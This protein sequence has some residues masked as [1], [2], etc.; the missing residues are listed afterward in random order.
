MRWHKDGRKDDSNT[1]GH[2]VDGIEWK[3]FDKEHDWFVCDFRN[4]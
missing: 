1:L 4:V 2:L 3:E